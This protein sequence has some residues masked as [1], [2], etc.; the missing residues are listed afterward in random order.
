[1][2]ST[3]KCTTVGIDPGVSGA[4]AHLKPDGA[5]RVWDIPVR[6]VATKSRK[7]KKRREIDELVLVSLMDSLNGTVYLE[8]VSAMPGQ[9]VSSMF[10]FGQSFGVIRGVLSALEYEY[11]L[12]R[13]T[14]WKNFFGI[15]ANKETA[16]LK[17]LELFPDNETLWFGPN[18]GLL[19]G[20]CEAALLAFYGR[21]KEEL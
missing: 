20:R 11:R 13:P 17:C 6:D 7:S 16:L 1:M 2:T 3:F 10:S 5:L 18:G 21:N 19:D 8:S 4:I 15:G 14:I 12:I 9:G